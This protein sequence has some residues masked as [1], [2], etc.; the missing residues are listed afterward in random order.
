MLTDFGWFYCSIVIAQLFSPRPLDR[1][2]PVSHR[3]LGDFRGHVPDAAG[4]AGVGG[5]E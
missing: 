5:E 4:G 3:S 1:C 2:S